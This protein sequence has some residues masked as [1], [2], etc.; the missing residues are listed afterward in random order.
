[1]L[2]EKLG[3]PEKV[4]GAEK[5]RRHYRAEPAAGCCRQERAARRQEPGRGIADCFWQDAYS[6]DSD[7]EEFLRWQKVRIPCAAQSAG[8]RKIQRLQQIQEDRHA[9]CRS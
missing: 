2:L 3:L 9:R 4:I 5:S 1:M 8:I 7:I 6:G